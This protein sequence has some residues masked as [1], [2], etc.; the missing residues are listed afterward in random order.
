VVE[1]PKGTNLAVG[2]YEG[3]TRYP[4]QDDDVAGLDFG[5]QGR[6]CSISFS[7]FEIFEIEFDS[8]MN[9]TKLALDFDH[10]CEQ[11]TRERLQGTVRINSDYP[12]VSN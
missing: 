6:G 7:D 2:K 1:A 11:S 3:A 4:F 10:A 5:G 12:V 8:E 9:L